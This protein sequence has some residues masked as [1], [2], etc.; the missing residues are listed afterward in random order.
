MQAGAI[1]AVAGMA[2]GVA[3]SGVAALEG[4]MVAAGFVG[5]TGGGLASGQSLGGAVSLGFESAAWGGLIGGGGGAIVNGIGRVFR[6]GPA[7][8]ALDEAELA[9]QT[10]ALADMAAADTYAS[11]EAFN[12]PQIASASRTAVLDA[13]G[14]LF[15][16][17]N[18]RSS[19]PE[20]VQSMRANGWQGA[21]IDVVEMPDGSLV[22]VDNT[23]LAAARLTGTP[24]QATI[25]GFDEAFPV[26]RDTWNKYFSDLATGERPGTW[27]EA[28][29]NRI[30]RQPLRD[31]LAQR[32]YELYPN[33]SPFTGVHPDSG[34]VLP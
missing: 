31:P 10:A 29:L 3:A 33:G 13:D 8:G 21:P 34:P 15:S 14:I 5:G 25:R 32:W 16:Q 7:L 9:A 11:G 12:Y 22:A 28:V 30:A 26:A 1:G 27:G 19:L 23:R 2:G 6:S 17:S 24:V 18:V 4:G 20:I